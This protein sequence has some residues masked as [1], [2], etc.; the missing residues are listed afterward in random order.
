MLDQTVLNCDVNIIIN[1]IVVILWFF[2][3][4]QVLFIQKTCLSFKIRL[5]KIENHILT[6]IL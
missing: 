2:K 3:Y 4:E 5:W 6:I 1:K